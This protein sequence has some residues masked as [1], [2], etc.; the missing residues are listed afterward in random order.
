M[1]N[2]IRI[3]NSGHMVFIDYIDDDGSEQT[4]SIRADEI[5]RNHESR[6]TNIAADFVCP[7]VCPQCKN[8]AHY[9]DGDGV[10]CWFCE[11]LN[12]PPQVIRDWVGEDEDKAWAHLDNPHAPE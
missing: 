3:E 7:L 4:L 11:P 12:Y 1:R 6:P 9:F 8:T 10:H 2:L 5:I